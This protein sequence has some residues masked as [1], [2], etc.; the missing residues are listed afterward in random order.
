MDRVANRRRVTAWLLVAAALMTVYGL[1]VVRRVLLPFILGFILAYL[2]GP[3]VSTL[4]RRG[5]PRWIAVVFVYSGIG[6][7][8]AALVTL[9]L[10]GL[11]GELS[12]LGQDIPTYTRSVSR[13]IDWAQTRYARAGLPAPLRQAIDET[14][15]TVELRGTMLTR[16][17][18]RG[19]LGL[20]QSLW[21]I[22]LAPFVAFYALKDSERI[23]AMALN[24]LPPSW[25]AEVRSLLREMDRVLGGFVRGQVI[26][27]VVVGFLS[28]LAAH[29][30][31]VRF[32]VLIGV[33]AGIFELVPYIGPILGA[34]PAV[35]LALMESPLVAA[36]VIVAFAIIQQF[37]TAVLGP[38]ILSDS[39]GLHPL[40]VI[41]AVLVGGYAAGVAGMIFAVPAIGVGKVLVAHTVRYL[42]ET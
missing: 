29:L 39:V 6:L 42:A 1:F 22:L 33:F 30:L 8:L 38:K 4:H 26:L 15:T 21:A 18:V 32:A 36:Q 19:L 10:P 5:V 20:L 35:L 23:R 24:A 11:V 41:F 2:I 31:G 12:D 37:E 25:H 27:A 7:A 40:T 13:L 14:L 34:I 28:G 17:A 16:D 9:V 3:L